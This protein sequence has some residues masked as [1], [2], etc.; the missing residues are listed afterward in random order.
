MKNKFLQL[1]ISALV[2]LI[3]IQ[4]SAQSWSLTGNSGT[5][6]LTNFLGTKDN[7]PLL[8]KT[9]KAER[10]RISPTGLV[11]IG[12]SP[13][14]AQLEI[15]GSIG[16]AVAM[17]SIGKTGVAIEADNPEVGFNY[18][19]NGGTKT[20][21]AGYASLIGMDPANGDI[22]IANSG[23]NKSST[24][25]GSIT[26]IQR[27]MTIKQSGLIG[28]NTLTPR[29]I[30]DVEDAVSD[31]SDA[32]AVVYASTN[33]FTGV[34]GESIYSDGVYGSSKF[35]VA[36]YFN[37]NVC[38]SGIYEGSDQTLKQNINDFSSAMGIIS[39]L[40]P[41]HYEYR[42][43]G[44]YELMN[45]PSGEHYGLVA[46]DVEKVLPNL[47]KNTKFE[48]RYAKPHATGEDAKNSET[49]NFKALNY[50]ELI[51]II[52]KG[53][54]ELSSE[55]EKLKIENEKLKTEDDE[56]QKINQGLQR[57]IDELKAMM[58]V[59]GLTSKLSTAYLL[60]NTPNPFSQ[61]TVIRC[62]VPSSV[63][64]AQLIVYSIDGKLL[65][66]YTL[67][68]KGINEVTINTGTLSS[69]EYIYSLL[70]DGKKMDSKKMILTK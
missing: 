19:Y 60:Q 51:P 29:G 20:I 13:T 43:D 45:L 33:D 48:T 64:K 70:V 6:P 40:H 41:K 59:Q 57:Q 15:K 34:A 52:I 67:N 68:N 8:F 36:G 30:L 31:N 61:N 54:Q 4:M 66:S 49:I 21:K 37:G 26:G 69:G 28:L 1:T 56:Q 55:N 3:S 58:N 22:Y 23:G 27:V 39:Q 7:K 5:N 42:H 38:A 32:L 24:D 65:K 12:N 18:Y 47:I 25:F 44:N 62:Y 50:T 9:N 2:L 53:M 46:Q 17:F 14:H 16:A 11:G 10:M 35:A 63:T